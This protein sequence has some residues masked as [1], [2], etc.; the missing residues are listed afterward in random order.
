LATIKAMRRFLLALLLPVAI[1]IT[2]NAQKGKLFPDEYSTVKD[3]MGNVYE[4]EVWRRALMTGYYLVKPKEDPNTNNEFILIRLSESEREK[5]IKSLPKPR[6]S[7]AFTTGE[8]FSEFSAKDLEGNKYKLKD[9]KGKII[10]INFWFVNC[11]PCVQ[12]MPELNKIV[13]TFKDSSNVVFLSIALDSEWSLKTFLKTRPFKYPVVSEGK[14][15]S[16]RFGVKSYPTHVIVDQNQKV[17][18]HT[19][20]LAMNTTYWIEKSISDLLG[21]TSD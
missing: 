1:T 12:E 19:A 2:T 11:A 17:F 3:S 21:K 6:E 15:L 8:K 7:N 9:L 5:R 14:Y 4:A 16:D 10:V 20:G 18:F 13:D